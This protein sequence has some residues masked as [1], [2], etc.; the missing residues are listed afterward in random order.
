MGSSVACAGLV[1]ERPRFHAQ[2]AS[3]LEIAIRR[4]YILLSSRQAIFCG[5]F[6]GFMNISNL[7]WTK[8][9]YLEAPSHI[10][11]RS[12]FVIT[13]VHEGVRMNTERFMFW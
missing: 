7:L 11:S 1:V 8:R 12:S 4:A 6:A 13:R 3:V 5:M 9:F 2:G 10:F